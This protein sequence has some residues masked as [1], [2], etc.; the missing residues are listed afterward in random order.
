MNQAAAEAGSTGVQ[1]VS[2]DIAEHVL[3]RSIYGITTM[4]T[5]RFFIKG[6]MMEQVHVCECLRERE[7]ERQREM[8]GGVAS[9]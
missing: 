4:P 3:A 1:F 5:L 9:F 6:R 2:V 7:Q 8:G